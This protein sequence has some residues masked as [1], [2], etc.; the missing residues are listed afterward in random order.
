VTRPLRIGISSPRTA[1]L[2]VLMSFVLGLG[3]RLAWVERRL[4]ERPREKYWHSRVRM[5]P[6]LASLR[7]GSDEYLIY[8]STAV[9]A[10]RGR[11]FVPDYNHAVDGVVVYPPLQSLFVLAVFG[12]AGD[13]V[14]PRTLLVVHAAVGALLV[15]L[16]AALGWRLVSPAAGG[17]LALLLA[18]HPSFIFW[19]G[20]LMTESNYLVGLILLLYLLSRWAESVH[21]RWALAVGVCLG[22]LH[23]LRVNG[24]YLGPLLAL[25]AVATA[26]R[27]GLGSAAAMLIVPVLVV[28]PWTARNWIV[29]KEP[30]LLGSH[31]GMNVHLANHLTLDPLATP[32]YEDVMAKEVDG[33]LLPEIEHRYRKVMGRLRVSYYEYS[34]AYMDVFRSYVRHHPWH[35]LRN[36]AI[37]LAQQFYLLRD[38]TRVALPGLGERGYRRLHWVVLAGG[39]A[40]IAAIARLGRAPGLRA[41]LLVFAYF[42]ATSGLAIQSIDGRYAL[43][44]KLLLLVAMVLGGAL[45]QRART[46]SVGRSQAGP[47]LLQPPELEQG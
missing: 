40:G 34:A 46:A 14:S 35:F 42:T 20:H 11:G 44:L 2:I 22:A 4:A 39:L 23:L 33:P 5:E 30:I 9:N 1:G 28:L 47:G 26:G 32:C 17:V 36:Y 7:W 38:D 16:G 27:R 3:L 29:Y 25:F 15:P 21:V 41:F 45:V 24:L 6:A 10:Y 18:L 13:V 37:K 19:T 12:A 43:N 8:V 31:V